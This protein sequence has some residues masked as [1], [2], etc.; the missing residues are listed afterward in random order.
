MKC[1][2]KQCGFNIRWNFVFLYWFLVLVGLFEECSILKISL[3]H[4]QLKPS[5]EIIVHCFN[6]EQSGK[7]SL[8]ISLKK[9]PILFKRLSNSIIQSYHHT[10]PFNIKNDFCSKAIRKIN[11]LID[12]NSLIFG[13]IYSR[14]INLVT[15]LAWQC[16][17]ALMNFYGSVLTVSTD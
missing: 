8:R 1:F 16:T 2:W 12:K 17:A 10:M 9:W 7:G 15:I 4:N 11:D 13:W 6:L 5:H 3:C 14:F